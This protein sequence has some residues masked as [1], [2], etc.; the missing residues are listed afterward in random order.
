MMMPN[1]N[2]ASGFDEMG[3]IGVGGGRGT[4]LTVECRKFLSQDVAS[5]AFRTQ[6]IDRPIGCAG[7]DQ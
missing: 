6:A 2:G 1:R 3:D 5:L 7:D 4:L